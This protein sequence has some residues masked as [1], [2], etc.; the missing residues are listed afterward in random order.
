MHQGDIGPELRSRLERR[1]LDRIVELGLPLPI[2]NSYVEG[3]LVDFHWPEKRLVLETDGYETHSSRSSFER[4]RRQD[5]ELQAQGWRVVRVT[6]RA[7]RDD[8]E[9][10]IAS[11]RTLLR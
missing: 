4:D 8:L 2:T 10:T 9:R 11:L 6:W 1:M 3:Y 5:L 7:L